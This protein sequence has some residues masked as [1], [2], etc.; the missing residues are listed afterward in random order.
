[1]RAMFVSRSSFEKPRPFDRC[2]RTMSPSRWST[3]WP[4]CS[5]SASTM[6]ATVVL[7]APD[8]PVNHTTNPLT[9]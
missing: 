6:F 9:P 8:N 5:S 4:R 7:P 3:T 2:E 1:M